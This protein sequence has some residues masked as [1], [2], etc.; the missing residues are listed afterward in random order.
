M[1]RWFQLQFK[2]KN[3]ACGN[4]DLKVYI[5]IIT[6]KTVVAGQTKHNNDMEGERNWKFAT[7]YNF[8]YALNFLRRD[9][10]I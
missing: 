5:C 10:I 4:L 2:K 1:A 9:L 6:K 3:C 7:L 8:N